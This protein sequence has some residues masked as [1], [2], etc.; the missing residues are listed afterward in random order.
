MKNGT[1]VEERTEASGREFVSPDKLDIANFSPAAALAPFVTQI[2]LFRC[3]EPRAHDRQPAALGH[4]MLFLR[5]SGTVQFQSGEAVTVSGAMQYGP[6]LASAEFEIS[7]PL[8]VLGFV[9]S[10]LGFVALTGRPASQF[11]DRAVPAALLFGEE[12]D[13][14]FDE[15]GA[16]YRTHSLRV[17]QM[18]EKVTAFLLSRLRPVPP[19]HIAMV[20]KVIGWLSSDLD[21]DVELLYPQL[22]MSRSTAARLITRYFGCAPKPLMRKYRALRAASVLVDPACTPEL[23]AHVESLFYDQPHMIREIRQFAGRTPGALDGDDAQILRMWLS[24]DNYRDI[25]TFPG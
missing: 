4:L 23:R 17:A 25:E 15:L 19:A 18:V 11:A 8:H 7:G 9:L 14:L 21:P 6:G 16:G 13:G 10:P 5:G 12:I 2:Y 22:G 1:N 24:K 3:D 20:Q